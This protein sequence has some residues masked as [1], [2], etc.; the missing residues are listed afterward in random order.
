[1]VHRIRTLVTWTFA[2]WELPV[3]LPGREGSLH[4]W[5]GVVRALLLFLSVLLHELAH[6]V[7]ARSR[8]IP[9]HGITLF[10]FGGV[11]EMSVDP[12]GR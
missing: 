3:K 7:V 10:I 11:A 1:M 5:L 4:L 12:R 8:G 2:V 6:S 9:V